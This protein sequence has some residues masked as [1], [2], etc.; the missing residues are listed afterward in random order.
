MK[1]K[2][3]I[4]LLVILNT[5]AIAKSNEADKNSV[6]T[7]GFERAKKYTNIISMLGRGTDFP[8]FL[9]RDIETELKRQDKRSRLISITCKDEPELKVSHTT[10]EER[11]IQQKVVSKLS[12]TIP[13]EVIVK[14]G[15]NEMTLLVDHNYYVE[16]LDKPG[17]QK[18]TQN[19]IV[20]K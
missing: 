6:H 10:I 13:V 20:K 3:L 19:F 15:K 2:A 9:A 18:T 8:A 12:F 1:K 7:W 4:T 16:N 11:D 14:N 5:S 17:H